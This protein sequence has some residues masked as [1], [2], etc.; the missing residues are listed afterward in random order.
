MH[1]RIRHNCLRHRLIAGTTLLGV[2]SY[3]GPLFYSSKH[4]RAATPCFCQWMLSGQ[5]AFLRCWWCRCSCG[6]WGHMRDEFG[7]GGTTRVC[8]SVFNCPGFVQTPGSFKLHTSVLMVMCC[9]GHLIG[10]MPVWAQVFLPQSI[11]VPSALTC[12]AGTWL[13]QHVLAQGVFSHG[14]LSAQQSLAWQSAPAVQ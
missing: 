13:A 10:H 1:F 12:A 11:F 9:V 5:L 8:S 4:L 7:G 14:F 3:G 2:G 6:A